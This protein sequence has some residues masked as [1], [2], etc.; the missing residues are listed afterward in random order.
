MYGR[1]IAP[2]ATRLMEPR[3]TERLVGSV[4]VVSFPVHAARFAR[5]LHRL[6]RQGSIGPEPHPL[7]HTGRSSTTRGTDGCRRSDGTASLAD[8]VF[9]EDFLDPLERL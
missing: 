7:N 6:V 4:I 3:S 1:A 9:G 8:R 2:A 5:A